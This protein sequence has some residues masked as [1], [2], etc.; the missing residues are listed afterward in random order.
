M[1]VL[2]KSKYT[3]SEDKHKYTIIMDDGNKIGP[4]KS[5]TGIL[6][7]L[8]KEAL[9]GWAAKES[10]NFFKTEILRMGRGAL[11]AET[12]DAIAEQAKGAH[13]R[14]AK[15]AADLGTACHAIFE[16]IMQG[17]EPDQIPPELAEPAKDFKRWRLGTDIELV[18]FETPVA[19]IQYA[20][21]GRVDAVGYSK[22]RGGFGIVDYKTSSS[23]LY[24]NE[25]SYQVGGYAKAFEEQ[26]GVVAAWAEIIRFGKKP[27]YDSEARPV[28]DLDTAKA[29]FALLAQVSKFEESKLIG[30]PSFS[31]APERTAEAIAKAETDKKKKAKAEPAVGF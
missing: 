23:L 15:D 6:R 31:T 9:I 4:L 8:A 7:I 22:S 3:V 2:P 28:A 13:R 20:Y 14:I 27:P 10:A 26:Y 16:A 29:G 12:L 21:G 1:P 25:Y 19:S 11:N 30:E 5:V 17:R 24:G 18:G